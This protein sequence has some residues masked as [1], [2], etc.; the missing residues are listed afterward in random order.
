MS[1]RGLWDDGTYQSVQLGNAATRRAPIPRELR[2]QRNREVQKMAIQTRSFLI[3]IFLMA[4]VIFY[5]TGFITGL[6]VL[7]G[8]GVLFELLFW[9]RLLR[10]RR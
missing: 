2:F 10:K 3:F 8:L 1:V 7:T 6:V 4:A 9:A 5:A